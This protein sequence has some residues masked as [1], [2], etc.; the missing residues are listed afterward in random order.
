[1]TNFYGMDIDSVARFESTARTNLEKLTT[2]TKDAMRELNALQW[3][4]PDSDKFVQE[5]NGLHHKSLLTAANALTVIADTAKRNQD[6]Q[7]SA[8]SADNLN[9][10]G[11]TAAPTATATATKPVAET[12][13]SA[14]STANAAS[15]ASK[16]ATSSAKSS[17]TA[18]GLITGG[19]NGKQAQSFVD[20]YWNNEEVSLKYIGGAYT[21][22][23]GGKLSNCVGFSNYFINKYTTLTGFD[24]SLP[25]GNGNQIVYNIVDRNPDVKLSDTASL[26]SVFSDIA[27]D[28]HTGVVL[29][30]D[31]ARG[32]GIIGQA[33]YF[34]PYGVSTEEIPLSQLNSGRYKFAE[35]PAS[36]LK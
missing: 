16:S 2:V 28:N 18:A 34:P 31:E 9:A 15:V 11:V 30:I 24:G 19:M 5:W 32:V 3:D 27:V 21:N 22:S 4:G 14:T 20:S 26:Y 25:S 29:G 8:S 17:K 35:I 33:S 6:E 7:S 10:A 12:P 23:P 36:A 13:K 1:M